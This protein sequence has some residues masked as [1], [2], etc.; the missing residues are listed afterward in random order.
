MTLRLT[1]GSGAE[2]EF[3]SSSS[4]KES[5]NTPESLRVTNRVDAVNVMVSQAE[6]PARSS[7]ERISICGSTELEGGVQ[8]RWC[9][10]RIASTLP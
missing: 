7:Y 8:Q 5:P 10:Q 6:S 9:K 3:L 2:G 1:A 4:A